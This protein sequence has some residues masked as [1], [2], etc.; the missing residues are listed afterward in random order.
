MTIVLFNAI[1]IIRWP[2]FNDIIGNHWN[3]P[4]VF[5]S[6]WPVTVDYSDIRERHYRFI[7]IHCY[8]YDWLAWWSLMTFDCDL[9]HFIHFILT[10]DTFIIHLFYH[11]I[12]HSITIHSFSLSI[13]L[14]NFSFHSYGDRFICVHSLIL[15]CSFC[16]FNHCWL[17]SFDTFIHCHLMMI[18]SP[19]PCP[20]HS[21][22]SVVHLFIRLF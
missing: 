20:I 14:L 13:H 19:L 15:H 2:V 1:D 18:H 8:W 5:H 22:I 12:H 3:I 16:L 11:Y 17:F 6:R 7:P 9:I 21:L 4:A 10:V